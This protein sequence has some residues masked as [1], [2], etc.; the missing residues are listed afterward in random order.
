MKLRFRRS[1]ISDIEKIFA[2]IATDN[3]DAARRVCARIEEVAQLIA[4]LPYMG[5]LTRNKKFRQH[6]VGNYLIVYKVTMDEVIV[7]YVR[8]GARRRFWEGKK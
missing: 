2:H 5:Q 3:P 6:P 7:Q 8:H 1:A 4:T